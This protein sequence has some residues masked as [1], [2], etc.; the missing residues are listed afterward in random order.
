MVSFGMRNLDR[1][2]V[3]SAMP[4]GLD[5]ALDYAGPDGRGLWIRG[6]VG[7]SCQ[8]SE[9]RLSRSLRTSR[10]PTLQHVTRI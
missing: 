7:L 5:A 4:R 9:S 3:E 10:L 8:S 6:S 1:R 2:P